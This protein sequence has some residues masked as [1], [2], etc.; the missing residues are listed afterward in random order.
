[1]SLINDVMENVKKVGKPFSKKDYAKRGGKK[2]VRFVKF[3]GKKSVKGLGKLARR[4]K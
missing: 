2:I 3:K 1:M 4:Y